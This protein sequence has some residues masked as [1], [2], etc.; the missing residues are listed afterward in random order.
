MRLSALCIV[1]SICVCIYTGYNVSAHPVALVSRAIYEAPD[2]SSS[3]ISTRGNCCGRQS[4]TSKLSS[5]E[6]SIHAG[7]VNKGSPSHITS[8]SSPKPASTAPLSVTNFPPAEYRSPARYDS[9]GKYERPGAKAKTLNLRPGR[10]A[11]WFKASASIRQMKKLNMQPSDKPLYLSDP[12]TGAN[13]PALPGSPGSSISSHPS[14]PRN[15]QGR[16]KEVMAAS[17]SSSKSS[18]HSGVPGPSGTKSP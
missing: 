9:A 7:S 6:S 18:T 11:P 15:D 2:R 14:S 16:G 5:P 13:S 3:N 10:N 4:S 12:S 8:S 17:S 1:V